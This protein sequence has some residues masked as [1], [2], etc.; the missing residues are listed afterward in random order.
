MTREI[1]LDT[2]ERVL[3]LVGDRA[4]AEVT[5]TSGR[6]A[7]T[8]FANSY[9]HQNVA[10]AGQW[11][12][13][14]V[15]VDGRL[16]TAS[17]SRLAT[18]LKDLVERALEAAQLRPVDP[19]WPGL[20][21]PA[22]APESVAYDEETHVAPPDARAAVVEGFVR[23]G[24]GLRLTAAGFCS[25]GG[26]E[27]AFANSAGQR[28]WS[29]TSHAMVEGIQR[30][31][32]LDGGAQ[33]ISARIADIDGAA[34]GRRAAEKARRPEAEPIDVG[35][36]EWEVILEP[37]CVTDILDFVTGHGFNAKHHAE[38]QSFV[39]LGEAQLDPQVSIFDDATDPRSLGAAFDAEGTPRRRLDL[40]VGGV[41]AA[42]CHDRR[43]ARA[44]GLGVQSTGH[45]VGGGESA[46]PVPTHVFLEPGRRTLAE[47]IASVER[48]LLV[49]DLWYTRI[50]DPK[51]TVVTGLT[52][53]GTF[54][55]EDGRVTRA[56][57]NLR[58]TQS[59]VE[60]LGPGNVLGIGN[61]ARLAGEKEHHSPTLHLKAW[62]FTGGARA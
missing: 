10:D 29:R 1:L 43:T 23:A 55:I 52:R 9:I 57:R 25:T 19:G 41:S 51:T 45:A 3:A 38:G 62:N 35:P 5:V 39:R 53:N 32:A 58:F 14:K 26:H 21:P 56:V 61:D 48:G 22:D 11:A 28:L 31:D 13:L 8:R 54:L 33:Q 16:A 6:S 60:A 4:E 24:D 2:C 50:L 20:A 27:T 59:Y 47:M 18:G 36:G 7:L 30:S 37:N 46:G 17:T 34:A 15:V 44:A 12:R 42:L 40:V 49:T